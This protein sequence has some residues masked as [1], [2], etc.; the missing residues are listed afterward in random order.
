MP[1]PRPI[2]PGTEDANCSDQW[3]SS[4]T[5]F[6]LYFQQPASDGFV[7]LPIQLWNKGLRGELETCQVVHGHPGARDQSSQIEADRTGTTRRP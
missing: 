4:S 6:L 7:I 1:S 3:A 2:S 5:R